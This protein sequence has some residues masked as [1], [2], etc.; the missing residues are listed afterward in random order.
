M[1]HSAG[2]RS[3]CPI[4]YSL[5]M[6][7]DPWSL[8]VIRDI[9]YFGKHTFGEFLRSSEGIARNILAT[10]LEQLQER[11]ILVKSPHPADGRKDLYSLTDR[12]LDLIP[13]LLAA[14]EWGADHAP[15]TDAP[16]WWIEAVRARRDE[17]VPLIRET[18]RAGGSIFV[19]ENSVVAK[20]SW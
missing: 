12:G 7:G 20:V 14:A 2:R 10:R 4:N 9:V 16:P 13:L 3:E 11:G 5:E 15:S 6:I 1:K 19:G 8:L 17:L 18:V